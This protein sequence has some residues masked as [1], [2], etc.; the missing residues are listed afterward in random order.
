[1]YPSASDTDIQLMD[2]LLLD[3]M[4]ADRPLGGCE[5]AGDNENR[6]ECIASV[7]FMHPLTLQLIS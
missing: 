4:V 6:H 2:R 7:T 3:N 5:G 1:M